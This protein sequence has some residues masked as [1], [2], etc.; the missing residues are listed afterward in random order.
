MSHRAK[1]ARACNF[2]PLSI[3]RNAKIRG[4]TEYGDPGKIWLVSYSVIFSLDNS[5]AVTAT[6]VGTCYANDSIV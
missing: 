2:L 3:L 4:S 1:Q 6:L 5:S